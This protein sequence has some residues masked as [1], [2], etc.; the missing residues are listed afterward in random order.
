M[1]GLTYRIRFVI[2]HPI[3]K[4]LGTFNGFWTNKYCDKISM[5]RKKEKCAKVV[6]KSTAVNRY[7]MTRLRQNVVQ[8][9]ITL[10]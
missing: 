6:A 10:E 4:T 5:R 2:R 1:L 9:C 3:Y 7:D 8:K